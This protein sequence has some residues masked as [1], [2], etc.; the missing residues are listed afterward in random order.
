VATMTF[1]LLVLSDQID[2]GARIFNL[3]ALV[4]VCSIIVHGLTDSAGAEWIA[5]R[6]EAREAA[7]DGAAG[8]GAGGDA[9]PR[10][11]AQ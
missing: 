3:A 7:G 4:V 11:V 9:T 5:S 1:S 2:A 8:D 10:A 6:A